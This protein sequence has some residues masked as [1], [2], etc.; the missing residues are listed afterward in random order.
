[1][2]ILFIGEIVG[3]TGRDKVCGLIPELIKTHELDFIVA[4]GNKIDR[5]FST[6]AE[7]AEKLF[8]AGVD[9]ITLGDNCFKKKATVDFLGQTE[10][11]LRPINS[12]YGNP[13][14]GYKI[15]NA[16]NDIPVCVISAFGRTNFNNP[17]LD[18]PFHAM[19]R[20]VTQ[21]SEQVRIIIVDFHANATSE[22]LAMG[23][24][25]TGRT[26]AVIGTHFSAQ[27]SDLRL[28][29]GTA[30]ITDIGM[31]GS[32]YSVCGYEPKEII[33]AYKTSLFPH[34]KVREKDYI[35]N[36][37]IIEADPETGRATDVSLLNMD[38]D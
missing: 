20:V 2:K 33:E 28:E 10:R 22:K 30:Y 5:G 36:S 31:V 19:K 23:F 26:T 16:R 15:L 25:M 9:I 3:K 11:V 32:K 6:V 37:L 27:T 38:L 34:K 18:N 17:V 35:F 13:G 21:V 8:D 4:N 29:N 1:M 7:D 14:N 24:Y 12:F